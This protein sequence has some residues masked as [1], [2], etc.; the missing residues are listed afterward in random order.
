MSKIYS[1]TAT[2]AQAACLQDCLADSNA[3]RPAEEAETEQ[4]FF[5][6]HVSAFFDSFA[7]SCAAKRERRM[8]ESFRV[9][10]ENAKTQAEQAVGIV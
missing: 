9:A 2:A 7:A 5:E 1:F 10:P 4:Q 6:R 3:A 8:L